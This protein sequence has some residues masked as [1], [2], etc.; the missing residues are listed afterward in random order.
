MNIFNEEF[1]QRKKRELEEEI[2]RIISIIKAVSTKQGP[3]NNE[4]KKLCMYAVSFE[5]KK[6]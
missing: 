3:S 1:F 2:S 5:F 4:E 6:L